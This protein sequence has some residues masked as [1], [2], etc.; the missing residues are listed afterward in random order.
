MMDSTRRRFLK[1]AGLSVLGL[2]VKPTIDAVAQ[3]G[4]PEFLRGPEA[5]KGTKWGMVVDQKKCLKAKDGCKTLRRCLPHCSQC[6]A[7]GESQ[8]RSQM[9]LANAF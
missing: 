2:G 6:P 3:G 5:L 8:A 9:D 4:Q 1:I 7:N